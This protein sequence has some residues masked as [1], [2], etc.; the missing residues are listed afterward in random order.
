MEFYHE[1]NAL[2]VDEQLE[3]ALASYDKAIDSMEDTK[4]LAP[5]LSKRAAVFLKLDQPK[6]ALSDAN[7]SLSLDP[8]CAMTQFRR[9]YCIEC[10]LALIL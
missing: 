10:C 8:S 7:R 5:A 3:S 1:A 6:R 9:G 4:Q 2:F